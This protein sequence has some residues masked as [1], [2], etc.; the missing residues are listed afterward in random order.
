MR[1]SEQQAIILVQTLNDTLRS[2]L[3]TCRYTYSE[4][5]RQQIFEEI[6]NQQ[7]KKPIELE[8]NYVPKKSI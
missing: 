6:V 7:S 4:Q 2:N 8:K 5:V 3:L 1:I